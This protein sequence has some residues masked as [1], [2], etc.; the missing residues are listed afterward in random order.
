MRISAMVCVALALAGCGGG[1]DNSDND[2]SPANAAIRACN[3]ALVPEIES[4]DD[5]ESRV[6]RSLFGSESGSEA[7]RQSDGTYSVRVSRAVRSGA[8]CPANIVGTCTV[9]EGVAAVT[10]PMRDNGYVPC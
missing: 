1:E 5:M 6:A 8:S 3:V 9:R 4:T 2:G 10:Q 7:T